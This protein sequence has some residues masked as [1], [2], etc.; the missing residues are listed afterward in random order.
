MDKRYATL[1]NIAKSKNEFNAL[2]L[3]NVSSRWCPMDY[4]VTHLNTFSKWNQLFSVNQ[5]IPK[6]ANCFL[7]T[8]FTNM[9]SINPDIKNI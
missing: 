7:K 6:T 1:S 2:M 8:V 3:C 5:T 9:F 4:I